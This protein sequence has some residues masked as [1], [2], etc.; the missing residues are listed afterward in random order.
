M[1]FL[2]LACLV[3]LVLQGNALSQPGTI[4][5]STSRQAD[6]TVSSKIMVVSVIRPNDPVKT[7]PELFLPQYKSK[8]NAVFAGSIV[9]LSG[10]FFKYALINPSMITNS[11]DPYANAGSYSSMFFSFCLRLTGTPMSCMRASQAGGNFRLAYSQAPSS[12]LA[13]VLF[14]SGLGL[15]LASNALDMTG[16]GTG[17]RKIAADICSYSYD[18][19]WA[20]ANICSVIYLLKLNRKAN[21]FL[22]NKKLSL[23]PLAPDAKTQGAALVVRF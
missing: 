23:V 16:S 11:A 15:C 7:K 13:W 14:Y 12:K 20:G 1:R 5:E 3:L 2:I 19:L 4:Q 8:R 6:S 21:S 22:T 9:F 17:S 18:A 10:I